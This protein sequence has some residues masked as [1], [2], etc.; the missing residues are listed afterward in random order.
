MSSVSLDHEQGA[1]VAIEHLLD[2]GHRRIGIVNW[3]LEA[4]HCASAQRGIEATLADHGLALDP[5]LLQVVA[6]PD[7]PCGAA[8]L[9]RLLALPDPPT[10][11]FAY[12]DL[13]AYGVMA[14]A[15]AAELSVPADL[16]VVGY[17]DIPLAQHLLP[18]LTTVR[19]DTYATGRRAAEVLIGEIEGS[20]LRQR[21]LIQARLSVRASTAPPRPRRAGQAADTALPA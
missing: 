3:T 16:S 11:V 4:P 9:A 8:A 14:A 12:G 2:L 5:A 15:Q 17:D 7:A 21:I 1:R 13:M 18:P 20:S 19:Q 10:A 6:R